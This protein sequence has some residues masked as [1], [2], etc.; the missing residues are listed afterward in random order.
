MTRVAS[1]I[2]LTSNAFENGKPIPVEYTADGSDVSPHLKW[3]D[4]PPGTKTLALIC[5]DPDAPRGI[6][7]HWVAYN[8]P[9]HMREIAK[10]V[11]RVPELFDGT[12]QGINDFGKVG[13]NG[14]SPPRGK[15]HHYYFRLIALDQALHLGPD[16]T[17]EQLVQAMRDHI[18]SQGELIGTYGR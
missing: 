2:D 9:G 14:P 12:Q 5:E 16:A 1:K 15:P 7:T 17:R 11:P 18:L 4:V 6:W 13:Y 8:I 3:A 10:G